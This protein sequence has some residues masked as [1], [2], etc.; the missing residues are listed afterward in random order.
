ME[1]ATLEHSQPGKQVLDTAKA[2]RSKSVLFRFSMVQFLVALVALIIAYPFVTELRN[3]EVVENLLMMVLLVSAAL[4]VGRKSRVLTLIL[5]VPALI[6]PWINQFWRG[7]VPLWIITGTH[8][9]FVGYVVVRLI[10][11]ILRA[12]R[13]NA[14]VMCAGILAYLMLGI[15]WTPTFL[16][17]SQLDPSSF[18][19]THLA[20]NG[21][22]GRFD[23]MFLSFVSLTC[24]GCNDIT[25]I[26]KAAR[27]LLM[28]ES[29]TGVLCLTVLIARL[30]SLYSK[31]ESEK[32]S[33]DL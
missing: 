29:L 30:V 33:P 3:G 23:A 10:Q 26:S 11:F 28:M 19:G 20:A 6:F 2:A 27:M 16:M 4:A 12:K 8:V 5:V 24:L 22:L 9:V 31:T 18:A 17:L 32:E 15:L 25:P 1:R 14:E 7:A 13:V 21:A